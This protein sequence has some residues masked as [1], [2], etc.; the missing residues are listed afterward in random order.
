LLTNNQA[1]EY[2]LAEHAKQNGVKHIVRIS[3]WLANVGAETGTIF[4]AH[5]LVEYE[6]RHLG[7]AV[8]HLRPADFMQNAIGQAASIKNGQLYTALGR[9]TR[10][11]S[12]D[13]FDIANCA[14]SCLTAPS[15]EH[16][17]LA[18]TITGPAALTADE[19][20]AALSKATGKEV[21]TI[22]I[23]DASHVKTLKSYGLGRF[24]VLLNQLSQQYRLSLSGHAFTTG[25]VEIITGQKP[26]DFA[27]FCAANAA[28]FK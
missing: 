21:K 13:A 12:I 18:Y 14:A 4:W 10:V 24:G 3:C 11:A 5:G 8:T 23:D 16:A 27:T 7:I 19:Y 6:M 15:A 26:R 2:K 1:T 22:Y 17:G 28:A 25:N 9:D 20:C